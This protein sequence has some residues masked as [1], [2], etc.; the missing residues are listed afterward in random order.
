[1]NKLEASDVFDPLTI[2]QMLVDFGAEALS[3]LM[4]CFACDIAKAETELVRRNADADVSAIKYIAHSVKGT[5]GLY[6]ASRLAEE[7]ARLDALCALS[8]PMVVHQQVEIVRVA[9]RQTIDDSAKYRVA[10]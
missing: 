2:H 3:E 5:A 1:M 4:E 6:G 8:D 10:V 7:A 9:C